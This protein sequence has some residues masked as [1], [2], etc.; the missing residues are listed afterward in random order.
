MAVRPVIKQSELS[1]RL[2]LANVDVRVIIST[3]SVVG[4]EKRPPTEIDIIEFFEIML[5]VKL[6]IVIVWVESSP[7]HITPALIFEVRP[8]HEL[9][10]LIGSR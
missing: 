2:P 10:E 6:L 8:A 1:I 5:L 7:E 9:M 3:D 4:G